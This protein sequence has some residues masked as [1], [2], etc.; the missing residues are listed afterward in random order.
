M[1]EPLESSGVGWHHNAIERIAG[2]WH[3]RTNQIGRQQLSGCRIR[4]AR[5][6][7]PGISRATGGPE[8]RNP[9]GLTETIA[10]IE[11]RCLGRVEA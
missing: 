3:E 8:G 2:S 7:R 5:I 4:N 11:Q 10:R 6:N 1:P 9:I